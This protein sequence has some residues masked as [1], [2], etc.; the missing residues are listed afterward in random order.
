MYIP[1]GPVIA[2]SII[3]EWVLLM[4]LFDALV[5]IDT[6]SCSS[7]EQEKCSPLRRYATLGAFAAN[8]L[9][10]VV[11]FIA[12]MIVS[13]SNIYLKITA[14]I[15]C[16]GYLSYALAKVADLPKLKC[17]RPSTD[18]HLQYTWWDEIKGW[19][20]MVAL[21]GAGLLLLRP[22]TFCL[23]EMGYILLTLIVTSIVYPQTSAMAN[24]WCWSAAFA[25]IFTLIFWK[26]SERFPLTY[27]DQRI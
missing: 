15:L 13:P 23:L 4:Q 25:P 22:W 1:R 8:I 12:L 21:F 26:I 17:I 19:T 5:W 16:V 20:Y 18:C 2:V 10:P 11:M 7:S 6:P 3:W 27:L 14:A 9:Q 24:M